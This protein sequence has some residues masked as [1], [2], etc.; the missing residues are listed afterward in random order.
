MKP[1]KGNNKKNAFG[2]VTLILWAMVLTLL[3]RSCTSSYASANEVEVGYSTFKEWVAAGLVESVEMESS[4][5][6]I[7]LK[8]GAEEEALTYLPEEDRQQQGPDIPW[9][10]GAGQNDVVYV[11]TLPPTADLGIYDFLDEYDVYYEA[12]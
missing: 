9:L 5:Y 8:E 6:V 10:Q 1:N 7:T 12:R 3:F 2:L 11:T 4:Q